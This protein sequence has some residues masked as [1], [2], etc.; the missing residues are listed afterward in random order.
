MYTSN[1]CLC[2]P[3][4]I[5]SSQLLLSLSQ[6]CC[7]LPTIV[8][9]L[10]TNIVVLSAF[11][12]FRSTIVLASHWFCSANQSYCF[13]NF[14]FN[15]KKIII[16][17]TVSFIG[18]MYSSYSSACCHSLPYILMF[19]LL[20]CTVVVTCPLLFCLLCSLPY[21]LFSFIVTCPLLFSF[22]CS[23]LYVFV[24]LFHCDFVHFYFVFTALCYICCSL[25]S[26][27]L[28]K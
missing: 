22:H 18:C 2:L 3:T 7:T 6:Q 19:S 4:I 15:K 1:H 20:Q 12:F 27:H 5:V 8:S 24:V 16:P 23:L 26:I 14:R 9:V 10:P 25:S 13:P 17:P 21:L 11:C 28:L